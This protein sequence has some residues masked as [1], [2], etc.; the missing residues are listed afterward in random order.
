MTM[1]DTAIAQG[2]AVTQHL[3]ETETLRTELHQTMH[4]LHQAF[5]DLGRE[6]DVDATNGLL[7]QSEELAMQIAAARQTVTEIGA[8]IEGMRSR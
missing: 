7:Q 2:E 8:E 6:P 4:E 3:D 5:S 1:L